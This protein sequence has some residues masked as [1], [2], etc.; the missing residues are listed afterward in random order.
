MNCSTLL[1]VG[2]FHRWIWSHKKFYLQ[3]VAFVFRQ[4]NR[5]VSREMIGLFVW[6]WARRN[7]FVDE[8]LLS[9]LRLIEK[10]TSHRFRCDFLWNPDWE[11]VTWTEDPCRCSSLSKRSEIVSRLFSLCLSWLETSD[12]F[13]LRSIGSR[14]IFLSAGRFERRNERKRSLSRHSTRWIDRTWSDGDFTIEMK[15][16]FVSMIQGENHRSRLSRFS[17]P[18]Y[19]ESDRLRIVGCFVR[20]ESTGEQDWR[21]TSITLVSTRNR[22]TE[23]RTERKN[24]LS[25]LVER[26]LW[27]FARSLG[28]VLLGQ[29]RFVT[30]VK[31]CALDLE[32]RATNRCSRRTKERRVCMITSTVI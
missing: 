23:R 15:C 10:R 19:D 11:K 21:W 14:R 9:G 32:R 17:L 6:F 30:A 16:A 7:W 29:R 8:D 4:S 3:K 22:R 5:N 1:V 24:S 20:S 18:F 12:T 27:R 26:C 28:V 31:R 13:L 25:L 2:R